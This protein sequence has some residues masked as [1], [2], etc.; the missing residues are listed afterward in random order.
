MRC[1]LLDNPGFQRERYHVIVAQLP[2]LAA[3][4]PLPTRLLHLF[5]QLHLGKADAHSHHR[6]RGKTWRGR[7]PFAFRDNQ[8]HGLE[9]LLPLRIV[10]IVHTHESVTILREQLLRTSLTLF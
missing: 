9:T 3:A 8:L 1:F 5:S 4:M 2:H 6:V 7:F 10:A